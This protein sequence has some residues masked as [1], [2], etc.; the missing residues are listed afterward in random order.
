MVNKAQNILNLLVIDSDS[1]TI[2]SLNDIFTSDTEITSFKNYETA[3]KK[4]DLKKHF[5]IIIANTIDSSNSWINFLKLVRAYANKDSVVI[6]IGSGDIKDL[7]YA[8][9]IEAEKYFTK[10][11]D[12]EKL[13]EYIQKVKDRVTSTYEYC[14]T[15]L[16]QDDWVYS[17]SQKSCIKDDLNIKLTKNEAAFLEA[18]IHNNNKVVT[19]EELKVYIYKTRNLRSDKIHAIRTLARNL[20]AKTNSK[21]MISTLNRIGYKLKIKDKV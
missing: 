6:I 19:Y 1:N 4:I 18:L 3:L 21:N 15:I 2:S 16:L 12:S 14:D 13:I 8:T 10:P 9:E 7:L 20:R 17:F 11:I 5:D